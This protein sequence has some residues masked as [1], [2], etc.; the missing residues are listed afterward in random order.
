MG[1]ELLAV[2]LALPLVVVAEEPTTEASVTVTAEF[3]P[4]WI[5]EL[6]MPAWANVRARAVAS[7]VTT[8]S[9]A[10][11]LLGVSRVPASAFKVSPLPTLIDESSIPTVRVMFVAVM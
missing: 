11:V 4:T 7:P 9:V 6:R 1:P 5:V 8:R 2:A 3:S 10:K